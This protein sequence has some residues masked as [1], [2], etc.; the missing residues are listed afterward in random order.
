MTL[1]GADVRE[2]F[3]TVMPD[4]ALRDAI[5]SSGLQQRERKMDAVVLLRSMVIAASSG[6]GGRQAEAMKLYLQSGTQKVVR[7]G[8]YA[9]FGEPLERT[10]ESVRDRALAFA[11]AQPK[12][13]PGALG[14]HVKDWHIVDSMTVGLEPKLFDEYP[15]TGDYAA[16]KVHKR[17]SVGVGTTI[18]FH[19]SPA[20]EHDARHLSIDESWRGL[21]L[22]CDLGYAS[23]QLLR[24]CAE[25]DVR[26]VI[27]LKE[28]WKVKVTHVARGAETKTFVQGTT[29]DKLITKGIIRL[30]GRV[31]DA[32]VELASG[33]KTI[34][35]RLVGVPT[36]KGYCFYL[37]NLPPKVAPRTV[38]DLYRIRWEI[39]LDNKLDKSC[40]RL[41][42]I[43]A[44][45]G[46]AVRALVYASIVASILVCLIT[47]RHRMSEA[48]PPRKGA[49]RKTPPIHAQ[50]VARSLA[51][52]AMSVARA[53][54]LTGKQASAEWDRIALFL[55]YETDPNWRR[56]PSVLDQMRGWR[57]T[58]GAPR[59]GRIAPASA[60]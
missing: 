20:R 59:K 8:F 56:R 22:L 53:F 26:Y 21:G 14:A 30:E 55:S 32:D 3:E 57:V 5:E 16:L 58:P 40:H 60:N 52:G 35:S 44:R 36:A 51:I 54:E 34:V 15:G 37:T 29:F 41:D 39:E 6:S 4:E 31:I 43:G 11:A 2:I 9:W 19:L 42:Q 12:D 25:F 23:H 1:K 28:N 33:E 10:L 17:Y 46:A 45:N 18:D 24:D 27:R 13:L 47:H 38:A 49:E 7:G 48:P 50:G